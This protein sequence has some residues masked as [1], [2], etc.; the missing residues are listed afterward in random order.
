MP[1][2]TFNV[3][4]GWQISKQESRNMTVKHIIVTGGDARA[5]IRRKGKSMSRYRVI[6]TGFTGAEEHF[7]GHIARLGISP[8]DTD[9]MIKK[10][11]VV[12]KEADS[13]EYIKKYAGAIKDAGGKVFIQACKDLC[14]N[15]SSRR[16]IAGM[17]SFTQCSQCGRRQHKK[18]RC[19]RCGFR[20]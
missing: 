11:P 1:L 16:G 10:A 5:C 9:I 4:T 12:L 2:L 17:S 20:L 3:F 7:K 14:M 8:S 18:T 19:E 6:F 15:N 13:L